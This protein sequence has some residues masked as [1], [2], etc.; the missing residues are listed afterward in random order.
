MPEAFLWEHSGGELLGEEV[1]APLGTDE[2]PSLLHIL[3]RCRGIAGVETFC[4]SS[5]YMTMFHSSFNEHLS[6]RDDTEYLSKHLLCVCFFCE[7]P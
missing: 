2:L 3:F 5:E 1:P 4:D 7:M 6:P